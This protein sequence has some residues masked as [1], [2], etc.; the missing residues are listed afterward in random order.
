MAMVPLLYTR[1]LTNILYERCYPV[2]KLM[3]VGSLITVCC[4]F[5]ATPVALAK[6][7]KEDFYKYSMANRQR[8][9]ERR[10][11]LYKDFKYFGVGYYYAPDGVGCYKHYW[12]QIFQG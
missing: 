4:S 6:I 8:E 3:A 2:K 5:F 10:N 9:A 1:R 11:I 7:T 12:V